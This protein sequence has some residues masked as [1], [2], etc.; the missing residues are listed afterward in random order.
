MSQLAFGEL[1]GVT[2][3]TQGLY[4]SGERSPDAL[5]LSA[6]AAKVDVLYVLTGELASSSPARDVSEQVLLDSYRGCDQGGKQRLIQQAVME[7]AGISP[8]APNVPP[9]GETAR[10]QVGANSQVNTGHGAVQIGTV[11]GSPASPRRRR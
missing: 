2:K 4:E 10:V 9:A 11:G 1:G 8:A 6:I 7:K 5:Y 3:K